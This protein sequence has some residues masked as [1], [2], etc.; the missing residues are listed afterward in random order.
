ME[1]VKSKSQNYLNTLFT[2]LP[3]MH[4]TFQKITSKVPFPKINYQELLIHVDIQME[5][6]C[7]SPAVTI[8]K[9]FLQ[10]SSSQDHSTLE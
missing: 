6:S 10:F 4:N 3:K 8:I 5:A 1:Q 2:P 7:F 9:Q